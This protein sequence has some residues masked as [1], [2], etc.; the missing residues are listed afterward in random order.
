LLGK[1]ITISAMR[2]LS[3][4]GQREGEK[5]EGAEENENIRGSFLHG[6][7]QGYCEEKYA[8]HH[9]V[10]A[11]SEFQRTTEWNGSPLKKEA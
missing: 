6:R 5:H 2:P 4:L 3:S 8:S 11:I 10:R 7:T 9:A 1:S